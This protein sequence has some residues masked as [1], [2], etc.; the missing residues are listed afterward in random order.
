MPAI[1]VTC[2]GACD[3]ELCAP[4]IH[5]VSH[6]AHG[7]NRFLRQGPLWRDQ[8]FVN[9]L[10]PGLLDEHSAH[11]VHVQEVASEPLGR[12]LVYANELGRASKSLL[13]QTRAVNRM[14]YNSMTGELV[15]PP[16]NRD[17]SHRC[18][19]E[20]QCRDGCA[21]V[22]N[23]RFFGFRT[24]DFAVRQQ[25]LRDKLQRDVALN[26]AATSFSNIL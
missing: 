26:T 22:L 2:P 13:Q 10:G 25:E 19:N 7:S 5:P 14:E 21:N 9:P 8:R 17:R 1:T 12:T 24:A 20:H 6:S 15:A 18:P 16:D 23:H 4:R 3:R 11:Y